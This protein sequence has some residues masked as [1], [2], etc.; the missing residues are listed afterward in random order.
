M[1]TVPVP[2]KG[3]LRAL[4][5]IALGTSCSVAFATGIVT[6]DRRRRI[7]SAREVHENARRLKSSRKYH[8]AG[9]SVATSSDEQAINYVDYESWQGDRK[10]RRSKLEWA[11]EPPNTRTPADDLVS[12]NG[13]GPVRE[14]TA[15]RSQ[16][17]SKSQPF[18]EAKPDVG[19]T[20]THSAYGATEARY[21]KFQ[22]QSGV[23]RMDHQRPFAR[24]MKQLIIT[25][26]ERQTIEV[27]AKAALNSLPHGLEVEWTEGSLETACALLLQACRRQNSL[28]TYVPVLERVL[29][30]GPI[31]ESVYYALGAPVVV[32][33]L[34]RHSGFIPSSDLTENAELLKRAVA[35][36]L[37]KYKAKPNSMPPVMYILGHKLCAATLRA[38]LYDLTVLLFWRLYRVRGE[39]L[40]TNV[41]HLILAVCGQ[42]NWK[43]A[44]RYFFQ[45]YTRMEPGNASFHRVVGAV[46][47]STFE[48]KRINSIEKILQSATQMAASAGLVTSTTWFLKLLNAHWKATR[49][50]SE[51]TALFN[52]LEPLLEHTHRPEAM[53]NLMIQHNIEAGRESNADEYREKLV[54][55]GCVDIHTVGHFALAKAMRNDWEG[56]ERD[57]IS[58]KA[59]PAGTPA[60]YAALFTPILGS[61]I[62]THTVCETEE[63]VKIYIVKHGMVPSQ[64]VSNTMINM[65][66]KAGEFDS[67]T[68]WLDYVSPSGIR[69]DAFAF[70][71]I[72]SS[73]RD[74]WHM[75][76]DN[77]YNICRRM[78][79]IDPA[80]INQQTGNILRNAAVVAANGNLET[81]SKLKLKA[82]T[83][84]C[85]ASIS[86]EGGFA[87]S[88][89]E[90]YTKGHMLKVLSIYNMALNREMHIRPELLTIVV[91]A[92]I[93]SSSDGDIGHTLGFLKDAKSRGLDVTTAM[94]PLLLHQME[95]LSGSAESVES[96]VKRTVPVLQRHGLKLSA[97]AISKAISILVSRGKFRKAINLWTSLANNDSMLWSSIDVVI[98]TVLLKA[99][100]GLQDCSGIRWVMKTLSQNEIMPDARFKLL[101][102]GARKANRQRF[103]ADP[104]DPDGRRMAPVLDECLEFVLE[105]RAQSMLDKREAEKKALLILESAVKVKNEDSK[106]ALLRATLPDTPSHNR[107]GHRK[108]AVDV[109]RKKGRG[110]MN[111]KH[112]SA[113]IEANGESVSYDGDVGNKSPHLVAAAAR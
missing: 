13:S 113:W 81:A 97:I 16:P 41:E 100:I 30:C 65:Y 62:A 48:A 8:S 72:L 92:S 24:D 103:K 69:M 25:Q 64:Y 61:F 99:Y 74:K 2:S 55:M 51:I 18:T 7:H 11:D 10:P 44:Q 45:F 87:S 106:G 17:M 88:I 12:G 33:H 66:A 54:K 95:L 84:C 43:D 39:A 29:D 37:T 75:P 96:M 34:L 1:S 91:K 31:E 77:L 90:A 109:A 71:S 46:V 19:F 52:R 38:N 79:E 73:C 78:K 42:E 6:E 49:S 68:K 14:R 86:D 32:S 60:E 82:K 20:E 98:L 110:K 63:F 9:T 85:P 35:I 101:L 22:V 5:R 94:T 112:I 89:E 15:V 21:S 70:N 111:E 53:Y 107:S 108:V 57:F 40:P 83:L 102:K 67:I 50:L 27:A 58:M 47:E 36:F 23:L 3:A 76:F 28:D 26:H 93:K 105:R 4:R 80:I 59:L 56:V 104:D